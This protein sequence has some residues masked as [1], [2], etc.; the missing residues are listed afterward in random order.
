MLLR[1]YFAIVLQILEYCW[2]MR[3]SAAECHLQLL[4]RQMYSEATLCHDQSFLLLCHRRCIAGPSM[5]YKVNANSND[6]LFSELPSLSTRVQHPEL[7][8]QLIH[9][10]LKYQRVEC[11][12]L[13]GVSSKHRF[14]CGLAFPTLCLTPECWMGSRVQST[15]AV[16]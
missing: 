9:W 15:L 14:E 8:P 6:C 10:R 4:E 16:P 5:L 3:G 13:Q 2:S 7:W 12:N 11:P 1:C